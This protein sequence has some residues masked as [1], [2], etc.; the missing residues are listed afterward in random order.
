[1]SSLQML[2][3]MHYDLGNVGSLNS[4]E[5]RAHAQAGPRRISVRAC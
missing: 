2:R 4:S 1:M 5:V 3:M